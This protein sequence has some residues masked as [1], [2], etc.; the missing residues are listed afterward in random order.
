[1]KGIN[2]KQIKNERNIFA[3]MLKFLSYIFDFELHFE[4][5]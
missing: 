4:N 2:N 1:L 3:F 5:K